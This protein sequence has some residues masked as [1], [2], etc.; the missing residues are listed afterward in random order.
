MSITLLNS[1]LLQM[2]QV[3]TEQSQRLL[4]QFQ[5]KMEEETLM[6]QNIMHSQFQMMSKLQSD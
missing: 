4:Q 6:R 2:N 5:Q 3:Q 1:Y